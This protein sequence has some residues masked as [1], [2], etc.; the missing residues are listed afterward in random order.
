[1]ADE[2]DDGVALLGML[3]VLFFLFASHCRSLEFRQ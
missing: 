1:M 3:V 2:N